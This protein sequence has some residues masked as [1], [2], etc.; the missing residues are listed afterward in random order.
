[1]G[2]KKKI[3]PEVV[4]YDTANKQSLAQARKRI[5][6][7]GAALETTETLAKDLNEVRR[8][9]LVIDDCKQKVKCA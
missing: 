9:R 2:T 1:M 8:L 6:E 7:I 3:E 4:D 5:R